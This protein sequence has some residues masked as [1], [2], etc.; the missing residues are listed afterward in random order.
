MLL[1]FCITPSEDGSCP[2]PLHDWL[3]EGPI[4]LLS[5]CSHRVYANRDNIFSAI[6]TVVRIYTLTSSD[7]E[8]QREKNMEICVALCET[9]VVDFILSLINQVSIFT[10]LV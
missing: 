6:Q 4:Q 1:P 8:S 2:Q 3:R 9:S 7:T 5:T 10:L